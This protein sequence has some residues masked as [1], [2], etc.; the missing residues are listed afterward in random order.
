M[1]DGWECSIGALSEED[2]R[3]CIQG[4]N[5]FGGYVPYRY[6]ADRCAAKRI[7]L[8]FR[9][10]AVHM[11]GISM[12]H[13]LIKQLREGLIAR[14]RLRNWMHLYSKTMYSCIDT[15]FH[16]LDIMPWETDCVPKGFWKL[17]SKIAALRWFLDQQQWTP[18][19]CYAQVR[20]RPQTVRLRLRECGLNVFTHPITQLFN[21]LSEIDSSLKPEPNKTVFMEKWERTK[22]KRSLVCP[23]CQLTVRSLSLHSR[24]VHPEYSRADLLTMVV[25]GESLETSELKELRSETVKAAHKR[26]RPPPR[27]LNDQIAFPIETWTDAH[28]VVFEMSEW[29]ES[30]VI[31]PFFGTPKENGVYARI[32]S[33]TTA[34]RCVNIPKDIRQTI[35]AESVIRHGKERITLQ[36]KSDES[37]QFVWEWY[38]RRAR[39]A[40]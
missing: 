21:L 29:S 2:V 18:G 31:R 7:G 8:M 33:F 38:Q 28:W 25:D 1:R 5:G 12:R 13:E 23:V 17:H 14:S 40:V 22:K 34:S 20:S 37:R 10:Y 24:R 32:G 15:A 26:R 27:I 9:F 39:K 35:R 36:F 11:V 16:D 30:L 3:I 4:V 6:W 19:H